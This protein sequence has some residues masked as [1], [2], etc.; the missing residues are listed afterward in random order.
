MATTTSA[1]QARASNFSAVLREVWEGRRNALPSEH[2][3]WAQ[4][5][6]VALVDED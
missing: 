4:N 2:A 6:A 5:L 3:S 1:G